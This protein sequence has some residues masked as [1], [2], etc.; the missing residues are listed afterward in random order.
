MVAVTVSGTT[1][2]G[3]LWT[4][5]DSIRVVKPCPGGDCVPDGGGSPS[6]NPGNTAKHIEKA[7]DKAQKIKDK[8]VKVCEKLLKLEKSVT[9]KGIHDDVEL[10]IHNYLVANCSH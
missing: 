7:L 10:A 8:D 4:F 6:G 1:S 3:T 5:N 9:K 2:T